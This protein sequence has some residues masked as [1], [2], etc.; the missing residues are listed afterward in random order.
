MKIQEHLTRR[1]RNRSGANL[2][3]PGEPRVAQRRFP[4]NT[5]LP[6][7]GYLVVAADGP[8]FTRKHPGVD[9]FI[10][11]WTGT[12]GHALELSDSAGLVISSIEF[13]DEGDWAVRVLGAGAV[14]GAPDRYGGLGWEW[15]AP[16]GG[17]GASLELINPSLP[18]SYAQNWGP[19]K[20]TNS[21]PGRA[22]SI[23]TNNVA[24]FIA[25]VAHSPPI[26]LPSDPVTITARIVDEHTTGLTVTLNWRLD[27]AVGFQAVAMLDDGAHGD[28]LAGDGIFGAVL[29]AQANKTIVEFYLQARDAENNVRTYPNWIAPAGSSRTANLLYQVDNGAYA[30]DQPIYRVIMISAERAYLEAISDNSTGATTDSDAN[31]NAT[32]ITTDG[33]LSGGTTTQLRYNVGV[34]NRGHGTRRSRPHNFHV[35]IPSDRTW[36]KQTGINLNSQ[37]SYSQVLG[38]AIFRR[39]TV[40]MADSRAVQVRVNGVDEISLPLPDINSFDSYAANEQYNNDFVQR[41]WPLDSRGNSYR[42]IRDP[43]A[44]ITGVADLTWHGPNYA[45]S[46]YTNVYFKQNNFLENDWSDLMALIAVLNIMSATSNT[47]SMWTNG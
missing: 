8:T 16:H 45:V 21:T 4:T 22:N 41:S 35:N 42:G 24:P 32:W 6:A 12:L 18:S 44:D 36:K 46:A 11:G 14:L 20:D 25:Q 29:P 2:S 5:V 7:G 9:N 33:V 23:G 38:S 30:G 31:M 34:R 17:A 47:C 28:G 15:S 3:F 40:P 10:G 39:L 43:A 1:S 37:Y 27:G 19:N 26:P 13:Y